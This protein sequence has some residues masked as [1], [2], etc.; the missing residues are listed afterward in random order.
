MFTLRHFFC[1]ICQKEIFSSDGNVRISEIINHFS[2]HV[3]ENKN[4]QKCQSMIIQDCQVEKN[5]A[6]MILHRIR[7]H[8]M[9]LI[10]L[11]DTISCNI[12]GLVTR[13]QRI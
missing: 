3:I 4:K 11:W 13:A 7:F 10:E 2:E 12:D 6:E 1:V 5:Y 9:N 8:S